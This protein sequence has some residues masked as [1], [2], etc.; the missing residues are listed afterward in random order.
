[1]TETTNARVRGRRTRHGFIRR[2]RRNED[3]A[4]ALEF[5]FVAAPFLAFLLMTIEVAFVYGGTVSLEHALEKS[6]RKIRVGQPFGNLQE[7]KADVCG[8]VVLLSNCLNKLVVDVRTINGFG[9]ADNQNVYGDYQD[10][11]G[12]LQN[13]NQQYDTGAGGSV[14]LVNAFYKWDIIAQLPIF[15]RWTDG[16]GFTSPLANQSD[17]SRVMSAT[18]AF[19]NEPFDN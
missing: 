7:F 14:V 4:T 19:K 16:G 2:L 5:A 17:G 18:V 3:G 11:S 8:N 10:G 13:G 1:M 12:D 15:Y 9:G 6:S